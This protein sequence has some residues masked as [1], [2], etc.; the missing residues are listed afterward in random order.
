MRPT[1]LIPK[2]VPVLRLLDLS[3]GGEEGFE[4]E[5]VLMTALDERWACR[6]A[7]GEAGLGA[8]SYSS[9]APLAGVQATALRVQE[10]KTWT[11]LLFLISV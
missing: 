5:S 9:E 7:A 11:L 10:A 6:R 4:P 1:V 2:T 3:A 8:T